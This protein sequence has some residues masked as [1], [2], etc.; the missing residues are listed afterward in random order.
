MRWAYGLARRDGKYSGIFY[1]FLFSQRFFV[2]EAGRDRKKRVREKRAIKDMKERRGE[3]EHNIVR[4]SLANIISRFIASSIFLLSL[5][6]I[7]FFYRH[8]SLGHPLGPTWANKT[9]IKSE[10]KV[11][12][13]GIKRRVIWMISSLG[14]I[15][16]IIFSVFGWLE[17]NNMCWT[18][19]TGYIIVLSSSSNL[20]ISLS[21]IHFFLSSIYPLLSFLS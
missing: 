14:T 13:R 18:Y 11:W 16:I 20:T 12:M 19:I 8:Y 17:Y 21:L 1:G 6:F 10:R 15:F 5:A 4:P 3:R 2:R 7:S 9:A